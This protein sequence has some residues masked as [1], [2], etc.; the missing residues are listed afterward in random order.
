M[1]MENMCRRM[2]TSRQS[3]HI[4]DNKDF[5]S[6]D[7]AVRSYRLQVKGDRASGS[8]IKAALDKAL[9]FHF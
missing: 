8:Q 3:L 1:L 9:P 2:H 7:I 4:K 6:K 5:Y